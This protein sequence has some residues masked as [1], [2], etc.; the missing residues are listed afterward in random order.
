[1]SPDLLDRLSRARQAYASVSERTPGPSLADENTT[2]VAGEGSLRRAVESCAADGFARS[3][4]QF[5]ALSGW[6]AGEQARGLEHAQLEARLAADGRELFRSL[7]QDHLDLRA[8]CEQRVEQ[9]VGADGVRRRERRAR[10][11]A[12]RCRACL[13]RCGS[14]GSRTA[15]AG[16]ENLYP[17][18]ARSICR[19]RSSRMGSGGWPRSRLRAARFQDASAAI[20]RST[21]QRL[22]QPPGTRAGP[23]HAPLTSSSST[24]SGNAALRMQGDALVLSCDGKGVVMRA[25]ALR[26]ET[27][28]RAEHRH[29]AQDPPVQGREAKSQADGGGH[30]GLRGHARS[31]ARRPTSCPATTTSARSPGNGPVAKNKWLSASVTDD[32]ATVDRTDVRGG[33]PPR[34]RPPT[35]LD[36]ARRRQQPP[37]RPDQEG[38][39]QPQGE[40]HDPRRLRARTGISVGRGLV[41]LQRRRPRRRAL[42][43]ATKPA[44]V[45]NGKPASS[46]PRSAARPPL[47]VSRPTSATGADRCADYLL[48]KRPYLD[49]PT[50]LEPRLADRHRRNRGR[51]SP[52]SQRPDGHHGRA[53]GTRRRRSRAQATRPHQQ[54]RLRHLLEFPPRTRT[55]TRPRVPLRPRRHPTTGIKSLQKTCTLLVPERDQRRVDPVLEDRAVLDQMQPPP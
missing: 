16:T 55:Q 15:R 47:S 48:A 35:R 36:R 2:A 28:K 17:A 50:A 29:Q 39:P 22:G 23:V 43:A 4:E 45:L 53:L 7:L 44:Q 20:L 5:F 11:R 51:L 38:G 54:R 49:Y 12:R 6:L 14:S 34:P 33:A 13:A 18:D 21:G 27:K 30:R 1:M 25:E 9:V 31:P 10:A 24:S 46:P 3:A 32:A 19:R 40:G 41:L 52:P 8:V 26:P 37:N 42:G